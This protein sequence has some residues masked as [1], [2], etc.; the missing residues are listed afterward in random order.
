M[1]APPEVAR[2]AKAVLRQQEDTPTVEAERALAAGE[3]PDAHCA[4]VNGR[5]LEDP[6]GRDEW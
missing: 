6:P 5:L 3:Q 2:A 1:R 4:R